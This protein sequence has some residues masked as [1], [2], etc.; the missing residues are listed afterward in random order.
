MHDFVQNNITIK[1]NN[2]KI[3]SCFSLLLLP[4][5]YKRITIIWK[6]FQLE[7]ST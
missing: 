4:Q 5:K 6:K 7:S 1:Q 2:A 3:L